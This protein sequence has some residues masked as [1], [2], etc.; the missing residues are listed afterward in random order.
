ML[1]RRMCISI[2]PIHEAHR[3]Q[4]A[5][6]RHLLLFHD[7]KASDFCEKLLSVNHEN[8]MVLY[9]DQFFLITLV[10]EMSDIYVYV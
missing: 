5:R 8:I 2:S 9:L 6:L 10:L 1:V 7:I 4:Q 3:E